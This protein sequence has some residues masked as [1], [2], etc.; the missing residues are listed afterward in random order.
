MSGTE[1]SPKGIPTKDAKAKG[2]TFNVPE[3]EKELAAREREEDAQ[4]RAAERRAAEKLA[5]QKRIAQELAVE[6]NERTKQ[7]K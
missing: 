6:E 4:R 5:E 3:G 1:T 7:E 2:V